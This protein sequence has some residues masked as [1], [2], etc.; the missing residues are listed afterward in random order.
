[1][2][3]YTSFPQSYLYAAPVALFCLYAGLSA[4]HS[5]GLLVLTVIFSVGVY[6]ECYYNMAITVVLVLIC[7]AC[8]LE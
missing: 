4:G 2:Q 6:E 8:N 3:V 7:L 5:I 1:M